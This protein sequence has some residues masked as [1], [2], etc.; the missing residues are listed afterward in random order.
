MVARTASIPT[1]R[2][3]GGNAGLED[4]RRELFGGQVFG[5]VRQDDA[6][7]NR[8]L[9]H[10]IQ[11]DPGTVIANRNANRILYAPRVDCDLARLALAGLFPHARQ[12]DP[13]THRVAD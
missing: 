5:E 7:S 10:L 3:G 12:F 2:L 9:A 13:V 11:I 6:R 4:Q 8:A 1:P